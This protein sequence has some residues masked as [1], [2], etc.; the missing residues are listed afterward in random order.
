MRHILCRIGLHR[1]IS[2]SFN[3]SVWWAGHG[4]DVSCSCGKCKSFRT[5]KGLRIVRA[6]IRRSES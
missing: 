1:W 4:V 6:I 3:Y 5:V 2:Y